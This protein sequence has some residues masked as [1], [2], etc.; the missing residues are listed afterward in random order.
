MAKIILEAKESFE[1]F[2]SEESTT[3]LL[4]G[5][6]HYRSGNIEHNL[7]LGETI[8]TPANQSHILTNIGY[9]ECIIG[10]AH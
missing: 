5:S 9:D 2:H 7:E 10:C 3:T 6:A 1:H 4:K 8:L